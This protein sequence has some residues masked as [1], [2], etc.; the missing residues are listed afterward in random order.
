MAHG[1]GRRSTS[2]KADKKL[3]PGEEALLKELLR[4][5]DGLP[6]TGT[7]VLEDHGAPNQASEPSE[8]NKN[9]AT[10]T[11]KSFLSPSRVDSQF[12]SRY[13]SES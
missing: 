7:D 2:T 1:Q 9:Q 4:K 3:T 13:S 8:P 6:F 12:T 10:S 5:K 11:S